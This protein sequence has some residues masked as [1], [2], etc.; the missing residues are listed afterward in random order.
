MNQ[1][2][3]NCSEWILSL[4]DYKEEPDIEIV[5]DDGSPVISFSAAKKVATK[6]PI[7]TDIGSTFGLKMVTLIVVGLL[8]VAL[9]GGTV[10]GLHSVVKDTETNL[11]LD[12]ESIRSNNPGDVFIPRDGVGIP[13]SSLLDSQ[14]LESE[15]NPGSTHTAQSCWSAQSERPTL[16]EAEFEVDGLSHEFIDEGRLADL[17]AKCVH[18]VQIALE[19]K[20]SV[21]DWLQPKL[22]LAHKRFLQE[23]KESFLSCQKSSRSMS[24]S[25]TMY[26]LPGII[27]H[28]GDIVIL[29]HF[30][31]CE[32]II[33][34]DIW[35]L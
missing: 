15:E 4:R 10:F 28:W 12:D 6:V 11:V 13:H 30:Y 1:K 7:S 35:S 27:H 31:D 17:D 9:I 33:V 25:F 3:P 26:L 22:T 16:E 5:I 8:S 20:H 18:Q 24:I 19:V 34:N 32:W 21:A 29:W 14:C 23:D 2:H